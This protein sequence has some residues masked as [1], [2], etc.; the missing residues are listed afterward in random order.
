MPGDCGANATN[1]KRKDSRPQLESGKSRN[2]GKAVGEAWLEQNWPK[3]LEAHYQCS[4]PG[5]WACLEDALNM[6]TEPHSVQITCPSAKKKGDEHKPRTLLELEVQVIEEWY[7]KKLEETR[8]EAYMVL[9]PDKR[10]WKERLRVDFRKRDRRGYKRPD[11]GRK[12][13]RTGYKRPD[14]G[15]RPKTQWCNLEGQI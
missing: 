6:I 8:G 7:D 13:D 12:R 11:A 9:V 1:Q 14:A 5:A 4:I 15:K 10:S 2:T 3:L